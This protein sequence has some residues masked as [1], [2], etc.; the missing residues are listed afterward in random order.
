MTP[1]TALRL[2][3]YFGNSPE[4]WLNLQQMYDFS[5]ARHDSG[6]QIDREVAACA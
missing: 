2:A 3:K 6:A 1:D 4:S 5:K